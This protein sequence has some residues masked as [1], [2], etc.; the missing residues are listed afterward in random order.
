MC[1]LR[2]R[3]ESTIAPT[4]S[5]AVRWRDH[6]RRYLETSV[7]AVALSA[8]ER[9]TADTLRTVQ[10]DRTGRDTVVPNDLGAGRRRR[11]SI[12]VGIAI[13]LTLAALIPY[14]LGSRSANEEIS[15]VRGAASTAVVNVDDVAFSAYGGAEVDPI[16]AALGVE[17]SQVSAFSETG[18]DWCIKIEVNRILA[19]RSIRFH[20][21]AA[22]RL[23]EI[24]TCG[25]P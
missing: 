16:A 7:R 23:S 12:I 11:L 20:L 1:A 25:E 17:I 10:D 19:T 22:G 14:V 4:S 8:S 18:A 13:V 6:P 9:R 21:D 2:K 15:R 3:F 5:S 24:S